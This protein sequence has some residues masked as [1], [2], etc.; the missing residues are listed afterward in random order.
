MAYLLPRRAAAWDVPAFKALQC[1]AMRG[2]AARHYA[3]SQ[4]E[5][6]LAHA[7]PPEDLIRHG[8][9]WVIVS[10]IEVVASAAWHPMGAM[11]TLGRA[12]VADR[13]CAVIRAVYVHPHWA[14]RG[15]AA[16]LMDQVEGRAQA[17][18]AGLASLH[19]M[20]GAEGFYRALGYAYGEETVFDLGGVA[21]P[22]RAMSKPLAHAIEAG[23]AW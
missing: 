19:A 18:G 1:A 14:R 15:L 16:R 20:R 2:L 17:S 8:E 23:A 11:D 6:F 10:G 3:A 7:T 4:V 5:A 22:G 13:S 9:V 21:F 12:S